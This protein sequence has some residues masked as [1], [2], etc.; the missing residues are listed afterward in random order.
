MVK[1]RKKWQINPKARVK[2]SKRRYDRKRLNKELKEDITYEEPN[3]K[4]RPA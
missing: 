3:T 4:N 2:E 1:I